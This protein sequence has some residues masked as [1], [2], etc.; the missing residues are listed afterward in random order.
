MKAQLLLIAYASVAAFVATPAAAEN[1]RVLSA[2]DQNF[3]F[4]TTML[5]PLLEKIETASEGEITFST[6]G[7][8]VVPTFEQFEPV[9]AGA[10]D[11]LFAHP[12]YFSGNAGVGVTIDA[13][14]PDPTKRRETGVWDYLDEYYQKHGLKLIAM[15]PQ[16][17]NSL[18]FV[19]KDPLPETD[20]PFKGLKLRANVTYH[21]LV[22]TLGGAPVLMSG[23]EIY[24]GLQAGLID[25]AAWSVVGVTDYKL[26][27]VA[28]YWTE[29][30]YGQTGTVVLMNLDTWEGLSDESKSIIEQAAIEVEN[31]TTELYTD[32]NDREREL[33][34]E[35]GMK[36]TYY[37]DAVASQLNDLWAEGVWA[38]GDEKA[39]AE[40]AAFRSFAA[41]KGM[42]P[43]AE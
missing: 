7:P 1:L 19:T 27:E 25:G 43:A 32:L 4:N 11:M 17:T 29:P 23:G 20:T 12:G 6:N 39:G 34:E 35:A 2:W 15:P 10:F 14:D 40:S 37:T 30:S 18:L 33:M 13:I 5:E 21:A 22:E 24:P 28:G 42:T 38:L 41:S 26:S 8:E 36:P 9:Q 3:V 16:G 31:E